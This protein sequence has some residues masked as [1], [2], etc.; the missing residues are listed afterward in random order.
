MQLEGEKNRDIRAKG[1][2][3]NYFDMYL[4]FFDHLPLF[5]DSFYLREVEIFGLPTPLLVNLVCERC[6]KLRVNGYD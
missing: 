5:V 4:A 3:T 1:S 2:F 6:Q